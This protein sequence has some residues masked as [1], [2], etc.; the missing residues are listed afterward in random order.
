MG[1]FKISPVENAA[2]SIIPQTE[3]SAN[4]TIWPKSFPKAVIGIERDGILIQDNNFLKY[5]DQ[6]VPYMDALLAV[7]DMRKKG[8]RVIIFTNQPGLMLGKLSSKDVDAVNSRLMQYL[9]QVGCFSIDG[10]FYSGSSMS[11]D[12][13]AMPNPGMLQKAER[14]LGVDFS[15]G[16]FVGN[17]LSN[18]KAGAKMKSKMIF[19]KTGEYEHELRSV[20]KAVGIG[21]RVSEFNSLTDFAKILE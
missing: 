12:E 10:L 2:P 20:K 15:K 14:E 4:P 17:R 8:Y 21:G 3:S 16:Y 11:N 7:R 6:V 1:R 19:I 5:P 9:G 18:M 13:Y